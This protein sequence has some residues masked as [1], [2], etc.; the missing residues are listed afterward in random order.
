MNY[1]A[2]V[3]DIDTAMYESAG[4]DKRIFSVNHLT[5]IANFRR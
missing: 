4:V 1:V 5:T 3:T 2:V